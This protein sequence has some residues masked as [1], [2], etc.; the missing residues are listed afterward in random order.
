MLNELHAV[1]NREFI[2]SPKSTCVNFTAFRFLNHM[3]N[4]T[5]VLAGDSSMM[6]IFSI[7]V[8]SLYSATEHVIDIKWTHHQGRTKEVSTRIYNTVSYLFQER[9]RKTYLSSL[10]HNSQLDYWSH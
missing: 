3:R 6:Q 5:I 9:V 7:F 1:N 8:C 4:T 10:D 2:F